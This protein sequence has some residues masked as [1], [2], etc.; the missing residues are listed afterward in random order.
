MENISEQSRMNTGAQRRIY[1][2]KMMKNHEMH[3]LKGEGVLESGILW[4]LW[5][6]VEKSAKI[7]IF[8]VKIDQNQPQKMFKH[9]VRVIG[10]MKSCFYTPLKKN[11][12]FSVFFQVFLTKK[13]WVTSTF[14]V[15]KSE[16][17]DFDKKRIQ[18]T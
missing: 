11:V 16:K 1:W 13:R 12:K 15:R 2:S 7:N 3:L 6:E 5:F 8:G 14:G 17:I 10:A 4:F 18:K 9:I